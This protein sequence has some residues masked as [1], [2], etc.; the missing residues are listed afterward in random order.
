MNPLRDHLLTAMQWA[1]RCT[2]DVLKDWPEEKAL[3]RATD[4]D[5]HVK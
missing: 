2:N 5:N 1:R 3:F 4:A